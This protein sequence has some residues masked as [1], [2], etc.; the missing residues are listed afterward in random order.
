MGDGPV[1]N[2][3]WSRK[4]RILILYMTIDVMSGKLTDIDVQRGR[5]LV[6]GG[7]ADQQHLQPVGQHQASVE[8]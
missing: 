6:S 2:V 8:E 7:V 4:T 1:K 3:V 5:R